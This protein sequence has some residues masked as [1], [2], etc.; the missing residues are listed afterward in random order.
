MALIDVINVGQGDCVVINSLDGCNYHNKCIMVDTGD[1]SR[2]IT[3]FIGDKSVCLF[4]TH[5][6]KDHFGGFKYF[7]G[8]KWNNLERIVLPYYQN[9]LTLIAKAMLKLKGVSNALDCDQFIDYFNDIVNNQLYLKSIIE[10]QE[11]PTH[12]FKYDY[13]QIQM[14]YEGNS[15]C[16][17]I[18]CL[19]PP[20]RINDES[21]YSINDNIM[22]EVICEIFD[23]DFANDIELY[24]N[25]YRNDHYFTDSILIRNLFI[26]PNNK[27]DLQ[28]QERQSDNR[29][30][31]LFFNYI[32]KNVDIIRKFNTKPNRENYRKIFDAYKQTSH[33]ICTVLKLNYDWKSVLLTGDASKKAF[34]RL[35]NKD[36]DIEAYYLKVPH[37]GSSNNLDENIL[38]KINPR[39]AIISHNNRRFGKSTD[40]HPNW[41]TLYIL[42]KRNVSLIVTNDVIKD[43]EI[44][45][46]KQDNPYDENVKIKDIY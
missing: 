44:V 30:A 12:T 7:V 2:D 18:K 40:T 34:N 31:T 9:E 4:I 6:D 19:N 1:G 46:K 15:F 23:E 42:E 5:H 38:E 33:D 28:G 25:A 3:K 11:F 29:K 21:P 35:I 37:H 20:Y 36:V 27:E 10:E 41:K 16:N 13:K 39:V 45:I 26:R 32:T 17:H 43:G 14:C 8:D 24:L 22:E